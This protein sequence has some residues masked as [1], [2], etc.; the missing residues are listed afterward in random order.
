[1]SCGCFVVVVVVVVDWML[2]VAGWLWLLPYY[3]LLV[4]LIVCCLDFDSVS[5]RH[6]KNFAVRNAPCASLLDFVHIG[7]A[8]A[9]PHIAKHGTLE[10]QPHVGEKD[11]ARMTENIRAVV[12]NLASVSM[13]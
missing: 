5:T 8:D 6:T 12:G 13:E 2:L 9:L 11:D 10:E 1:M 4:S 3:A 7:Q